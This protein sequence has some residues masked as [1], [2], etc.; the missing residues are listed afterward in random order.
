MEYVNTLMRSHD[1]GVVTETRE[2]RERKMSIDF[3][4]LRDCKYF[5]DHI[6]QYKG[7][8]GI[9]IKNSFLSR[10]P[11]TDMDSCWKVLVPGRVG[12]LS[13]CGPEGMLHIF[14]VYLDP[15]DK[16]LRCQHLEKI[17]TYVTS[18]AHTIVVGDFNFV[19]HNEDRWCTASRV[20]AHCPTKYKCPFVLAK[21]TSHWIV[22][23]GNTARLGCQ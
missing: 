1:F 14:A 2:T 17:R 5:S 23:Q 8:I 15:G 19:E 3:Q 4:F 9:F 22:A 13:L 12:K 10:F 6:D 11:Q 20:L 18:A 7:G 16:A 21:Q